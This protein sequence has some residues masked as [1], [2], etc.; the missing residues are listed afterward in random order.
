RAR[1]MRLPTHHCHWW[2]GFSLPLGVGIL[3]VVPAT[4]RPRP[5]RRDRPGPERCAAV[6]VSGTR[7]VV[8]RCASAQRTEDAAQGAEDA[9]VLAVVAAVV[10][11]DVLRRRDSGHLDRQGGLGALLDT[12]AGGVV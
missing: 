6:P 4:F 11:V 9:A 3:D 8:C 5:F 10:V 2:V 7:R 12:A 1:A